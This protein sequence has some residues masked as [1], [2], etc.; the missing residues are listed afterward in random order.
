[1]F[2][3]FCRIHFIYCRCTE[4]FQLNTVV[5]SVCV[6]LSE[7]SVISKAVVLSMTCK[8]RNLPF[9]SKSGSTKSNLLRSTALSHNYLQPR[10][11]TCLLHAYFSCN[12]APKSKKQEIVSIF[13]KTYVD[14]SEL[15]K[16]TSISS[17]QIRLGTV[18]WTLFSLHHSA[19]QHQKH[20]NSFS[21]KI[22]PQP[23]LIQC[24]WQWLPYQVLELLHML[25]FYDDYRL[26]QFHETAH[27]HTS[28]L[29]LGL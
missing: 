16:V 28:T 15:I 8:Q 4:C 19:A 1:M 24:Y 25:M 18:I 10:G 9:K 12:S 17:K 20:C 11:C 7:C 6:H 14:I 22:I 2:I 21:Y 27:M 5:L 29:T 26:C 3:L 23:S 13:V